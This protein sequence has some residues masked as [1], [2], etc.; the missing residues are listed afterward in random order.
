[1]KTNGKHRSTQDLIERYGM[2]QAEA[3]Y[4]PDTLCQKCGKEY[5]ASD[6]SFCKN[7]QKE[8]ERNSY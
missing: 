7:C 8:G 4:I 3:H 6:S 2:T 5:R 1:M